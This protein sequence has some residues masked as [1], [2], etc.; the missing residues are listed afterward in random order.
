MPFLLDKNSNQAYDIK[1]E[2]LKYLNRLV[3]VIRFKTRKYWLLPVNENELLYADFSD[4]VDKSGMRKEGYVNMSPM[5]GLDVPITDESEVLHEVREL[6]KNEHIIYYSDSL[7]LDAYTYILLGRY[8]DSIATSNLALEMFILEILR[9]ILQYR[10]A[11]DL[12]LDD[13]LKRVVEDKLHATFRKNFLNGK[14][15]DELMRTSDVYRKFDASRNYRAKIMHGGKRLDRSEA[16]MNLN[17][18]HAVDGY[19]INNSST[20][21]PIVIQRSQAGKKE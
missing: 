4:Y 14:K 1:L 17:N 18:I 15:H 8:N 13:A 19:L 9:E 12:E 16:V 7:I 6:L 11:T 20:Y 2:C 10:Y 21:G 5:F 3:E